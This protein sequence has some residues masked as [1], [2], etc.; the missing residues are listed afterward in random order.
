MPIGSVQRT[1]ILSRSP[2]CADAQRGRRR[3][4][5]PS[6]DALQHRRCPVKAHI[7]FLL[8]GALGALALAAPLAAQES[9]PSSVEIA[10]YA[11]Y[12]VSNSLVDGPLGTGIASSG[13]TL[14]GIQLGIPLTSNIA[15]VG[16][17][18]RAQGDLEVGLPIVGGIPFGESSMWM[19]DAGVQLGMPMGAGR[20]RALTPFVQL[21][22]GAMRQSLEITGSSATATNFAVNAG[23]G[24]D[25]AF[26]PNIGLRVMA[27]DYIG[28]FDF[29]EATSF[30]LDRGSA[31]NFALSAGL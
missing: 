15:I 26:S 1:R 30:D 25:L 21:G 28:K 6:F 24:V 18:A 13:R 11:G 14:Y 8:A 9:S 20:A 3:D 5:L 2:A 29:E 16:N 23:A 19:M 22:A 27:K 12:M 31:H 4:Q 17:L 7:V 10:P